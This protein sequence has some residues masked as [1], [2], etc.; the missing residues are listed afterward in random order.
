MRKFAR[1]LSVLLA[2]LAGGCGPAALRLH[3]QAASVTGI[4]L[5][6][7]RTAILQARSA[8]LD[9]VEGGTRGQPVAARLEALSTEDRGWRP[10]LHAF[11]GV[12]VSLRIWIDS[13]ALAAAAGEGEQIIGNLI[14]IARDLVAGW[15]PLSEALRDHG[16][17][18]PE[19]PKI[20]SDLLE[21]LDDGS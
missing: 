18:A 20:V 15:A 1:V 16:I 3:A 5:S 10:V 12:R 21:A 19:L 6:G 8:A 9:R 7:T 13:I 2:F 11:E 17:D 4:A 14:A